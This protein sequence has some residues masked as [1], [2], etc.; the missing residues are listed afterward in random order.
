MAGSSRMQQA[1]SSEAG[2]PGLIEKPARSA[3][4]RPNETDALRHFLERSS[5]HAF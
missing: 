1:N 4:L 2:G 5:T 3:G